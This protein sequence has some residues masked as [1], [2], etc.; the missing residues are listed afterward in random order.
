MIFVDKPRNIPNELKKIQGEVFPLL[1]EKHLNEKI[2]KW[3]TRHYSEPIKEQVKLLYNNKCAFCESKMEEQSTDRQFTIE[4]YRPKG[5]YNWLGAEWTNLFPTCHGCNDNKEDEFPLFSSINKVKKPPFDREGNL[6][7]E[8]CLANSPELLNENPLFIHPE[9]DKPEVYFSFD[10]YGKAYINEALDKNDTE[11]ARKMLDKFINRPVV[12]QRRKSKIVK[13]Q[14]DLIML[15][16]VLMD[17][18]GSKYSDKEIEIGFAGFFNRLALEKNKA[19][20][21][22]LFGYY[23][24]KNFDKFFLDYLEEKANVEVRHFVEYA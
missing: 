5:T 12:E 19:S 11:R 9:V 13:Y 4:H 14:T 15:V 2:F 3:E 17:L 21:Y 1:H 10:K 20:E 6:V 16:D 7:M 22:S 18:L 8:R 24:W 23:M